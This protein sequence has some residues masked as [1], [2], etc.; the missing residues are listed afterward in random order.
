MA[1][2]PEAGSSSSRRRH[3]PVV[4]GIVVALLVAAGVGAAVAAL[5]DDDPSSSSSSAS[6]VCPAVKVARETLPSV[7]TI[8]VQSAGAGGFGSGEVIRPG[9]EILTNDHVV[10]SAA[11]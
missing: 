8:Q 5:I 3:W 10:S 2:A 6:A 11:V 1:V 7:V 4:A 9:G